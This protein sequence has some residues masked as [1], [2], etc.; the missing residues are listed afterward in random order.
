MD[1]DDNLPD[2]LKGSKPQ[3]VA[4]A[5]QSLDSEY[6]VTVGSGWKVKGDD[7]IVLRLDLLPTKWDGTILLARSKNKKILAENPSTKGH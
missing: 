4:F 7:T 3:Y 2:E 5:R 1:T 6:I